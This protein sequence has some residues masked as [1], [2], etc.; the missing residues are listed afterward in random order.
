M[1]SERIVKKVKLDWLSHFLRLILF[2]R[3]STCITYE[4]IDR[5]FASAR[6]KVGLKAP[7]RQSNAPNNVDTDLLGRTIVETSRILAE[8]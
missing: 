2:R 6:K 4:D 5:A 7:N 8:K 3:D 1:K